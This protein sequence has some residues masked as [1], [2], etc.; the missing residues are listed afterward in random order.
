MTR[1]DL[2]AAIVF[3]SGA[4]LL[5]VALIIHYLREKKVTIGLLLSIT[6]LF[7]A[8]LTRFPNLQNEPFF[9]GTIA[10]FGISVVVSLVELA[11]G[12]RTRHS[13]S[14]SKPEAP[15]PQGASAS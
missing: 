8:A 7:C 10:L 1:E 4:G 9:W 12:I 5:L 15:G 11:I 3:A 2:I 6:G 14:P 13:P